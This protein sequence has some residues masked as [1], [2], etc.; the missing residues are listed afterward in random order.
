MKKAPNCFTDMFFILNRSSG[1]WSF[2]CLFNQDWINALIIRKNGSG[3]ATKN[4]TVKK[5]N[6]QKK[7][8]VLKFQKTK[9]TK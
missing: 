1:V 8:Q 2:F 3:P 9:R 4:H 5:K 6:N 7:T